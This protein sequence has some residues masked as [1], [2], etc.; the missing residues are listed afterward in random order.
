MDTFCILGNS[1]LCV[2]GSITHIYIRGGVM[3]DLWKEFLHCRLGML[4]I[5]AT[6]FYLIMVLL[7]AEL[8]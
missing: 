3:K 7:E 4:L 8:I 2:V 6:G 1:D 5:F